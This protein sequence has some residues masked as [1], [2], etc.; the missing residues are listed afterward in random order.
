ML[1]KPG[2]VGRGRG[3]EP[4]GGAVVRVGGDDA[5]RLVP[6]GG[7]ADVGRALEGVEEVGVAVA[8]H[9]EDVVDVAGE[10]GGDVRGDG[11]HGELLRDR[12]GR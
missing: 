8:H 2:A 7:E 3:G 12:D 5:A 11:G 4:A 10:G 6:H 1:V 9:P